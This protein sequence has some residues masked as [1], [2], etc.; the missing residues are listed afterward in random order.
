MNLLPKIA[1]ALLV[2]GLVAGQTSPANSQPPVGASDPAAQANPAPGGSAPAATSSPAAVAPSAKPDAGGSGGPNAASTHAAAQPGKPAATDSA[3][4]VLGPNDVVEVSV[5]R[6]VNLSRTY[7]IGPDGRMSMH[8]INDFKAAGLTVPELRDLITEKL[9]GFI[10][11]PQVNV[12]LL[13]VNSKKY[14]LVGGVLRGG[15]VT[16][17]QETTVLDALAAAGGFKDFANKKKIV[18]RRGT[19]T[20][21]FN[22]NDVIKGKHT[23]Q[24][25]QLQDGDIIIVPEQ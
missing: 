2:A 5:W 11:D 18:I 9:K 14:L 6:D 13:R 21:P 25:I 17:L 24:N 23:E 3:L 1:A 15:P 16:L 20:F 8:L 19:K 10:N 22:Y 12:Q 4:Y 7:A